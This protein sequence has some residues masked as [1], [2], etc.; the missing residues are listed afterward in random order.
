MKKLIKISVLLFVIFITST[1]FAGGW[2]KDFGY[3]NYL[4]NIGAEYNNN[5]DSIF[6]TSRASGNYLPT[7]DGGVLVY[8]TIFDGSRDEF[9]F[10]LIKF[11]KYG[12][13]IWQKKMFSDNK[14]I[15]DTTSIINDYR[16]PESNAFAL[17]EA[18]ENRFIIVHNGPN[19]QI[20]HIRTGTVNYYDHR[21]IRYL[22]TIDNMGNI[23]DT[24][25]SISDT[26]FKSINNYPIYN[27][28]LLFD[29]VNNIY[30]YIHVA[31]KNDKIYLIK[32]KYDT[33]LNFIEGNVSELDTIC[34]FSNFSIS[35]EDSLLILF[36]HGLQFGNIYALCVFNID[37]DFKYKVDVSSDI[38][39]FVY[40]ELKQL[41]PDFN[42]YLRG[43]PLRDYFFDNYGNLNLFSIGS[44]STSS[45][46]I[47]TAYPSDLHFLAHYKV[48]KFGYVFSKKLIDLTS[49]LSNK[50]SI[51]FG[52]NGSF[53]NFNNSI[54]DL[55]IFDESY[56]FKNYNLIKYDIENNSVLSSKHFTNFGELSKNRI[57]SGVL[58][59][60]KK[61]ILGNV[62]ICI[63]QNIYSTAVDK[64]FKIDSLGNI[65]TH[66]IQ[67]NVYADQN[68]NC[69]KNAID[70][71][72][73][74]ITVTAQNNNY[75]AYTSSDNNGNYSIAVDDSGLYIV[76]AQS[77]IN[78][79]LFTQNNCPIQTS[80]AYLDS[81]TIDTIN[82]NLKPTILCPNMYVDIS[83]PRLRRCFSN[84]YT[85]NY[86][87]N[88]SIASP[89]TYVDITLDRFL[90][91]NSASKPYTNL[92]N[93][94]LRF[95]LGNVDYLSSGSFTI[96]VTVRCDSTVLGQTHCVEA[97]IYPDTVC[98]V[99]NYTG[100]VISASAQC[101]LDSVEFKLKNTGGN[102]PTIKRYIVIEDNLNRLNGNYQLNTNQEKI[103]AV[104]SDSGKTYRI[105]A[106]QDD[107]FPSALGDKFATAFIE[108]C[109]PINNT[110][111]TGF[112]TQ[113]PEFDGQ[114]YASTDCQQNIGAFDPN[115]KTGYP[116]GVSSSHN[117][118]KNTAIDYHI[119]FQNT[120]TDTA[121][122]VVIVDSISKYLDINTIEPGASSHRYTFMRTDSNVVKFIFD[123][124]K[125]IDSNKNEKLSHGF[126]KFRIQQKPNNANGTKIYNQAEIYFD[127]NSPIFT[128]TTTHTIGEVY[129]R[130]LSKIMN[131]NYQKADV[132]IYPN[133]FRDNAIIEL[134]Y[135]ELQKTTLILYDISGK[136]IMQLKSNN[137]QYQINGNALEKGMYLFKIKNDKE[138]IASGKLLLQ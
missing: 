130:L 49:Y 32:N 45:L 24:K 36:N 28:T 46:D 89:N 85:V 94:V 117:I 34:K 116:I 44:Y 59:F 118:E 4:N 40:N 12:K 101:K 107:L 82:L 124:I 65:N 67:G 90:T 73:P 84:I 133:P 137:N 39:T 33:L 25:Y 63:L 41:Y 129:I 97:H 53:L 91:V 10:Y 134:Q 119:N 102:M 110:F 81:F 69:L 121:F 70:K 11:D 29:S 93:N 104:K 64:L 21:A 62:F 22:T 138:E 58:P 20:A 88:G 120:G 109:N 99:A 125:L 112:V 113:Y 19:I 2:Q 128:N 114:P 6:E 37:G 100:P 17:T 43:S 3:K 83:T 14:I 54:L 135:L 111:T 72:F 66:A 132:K 96:D 52:I 47:D 76:K 57:I 48:D 61:S 122:K 27:N 79:P 31:A 35:V 30:K 78:Y 131:A 56:R 71:N 60:K 126:M 108:G 9:F 55:F 87:N 26:I 127:Y 7:K 18:S 1:A 103:I 8:N 50:R 86:K 74:Q 105:I 98:A 106:E 16:T 38:N 77:N 95:Q 42:D 115:D 75:T 68:S 80:Y 13:F 51:Y 15:T 123:S 92:G 5:I 136:E 23:I